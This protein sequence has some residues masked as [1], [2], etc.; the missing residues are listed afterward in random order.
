MTTQRFSKARALNALDARA[1]LLAQMHKLN[2]Q[3]GTAQLKMTCSQEELD[4]A[5]DY[6]RMRAL[7]EF[8]RLIEEGRV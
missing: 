1:A 8:A 2:R 6:G 4:R 7:E 3:H 5:I